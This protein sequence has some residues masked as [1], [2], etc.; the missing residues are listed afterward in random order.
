V[1]NPWKKET[2]NLTEQARLLREDPELAKQM[3]AAAG[4]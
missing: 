3:K 1:V 4:A 2:L